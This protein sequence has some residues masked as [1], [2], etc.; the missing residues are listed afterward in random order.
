VARRQ[1]PQPTLD[2]LTE[3]VRLAFP[4]LDPAPP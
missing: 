3:A 4:G 1:D 2:D